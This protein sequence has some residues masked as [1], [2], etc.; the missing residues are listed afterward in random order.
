MNIDDRRADDPLAS[1]AYDFLPDWGSL[2]EEYLY[3]V[4]S[5]AETATL[6]SRMAG[7]A[8]LSWCAHTGYMDYNAPRAELHR[9]IRED[10]MTEAA[11]AAAT[12]RRGVRPT[13]F[14]LGGRA[15]APK[16]W[17]AGRAYDPARVLLLD[18]DAIMARLPE[19]ENGHLAPVVRAEAADMVESMLDSARMMRLN[20]GVDVTLCS[21]E[22]AAAKVEAFKAARYRIELHY[23]FVPRQVAARRVVD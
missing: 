14:I 6:V 18:A 17:F 10:I 8:P 13:F 5:D 16:A 20:V 21:A 9:S 1:D 19:Y 23:M 15:G 12:P 2:S 4:V 7:R 22:G 11:I 3:A